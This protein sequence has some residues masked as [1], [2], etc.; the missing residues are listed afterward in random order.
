MTTTAVNRAIAAHEARHAAAA[1]LLGLD[2]LEARADDPNP[3]MGGYVQLAANTWLRPRESGIMTLAGRWGDLGWPPENP[4]KSGRTFDERNLADDVESL[5]RGQVGYRDMVADTERLVERP[6]FK[7]LTGVLESLL[8]AGCVLRE[9]HIRL[10]HESCGKPELAHKT[11]KAAA[12]VST[13]LGEFSALAAAWSHDRDGDQIVR[14]AF[15]GSIERWQ[16]SGKRVPLHYNHSANPKHIIGWVDP[17]SMREIREGLFVR[18]KLDLEN[19]EVARD[20]WQ[21]VKNNTISLSFGY[22]VNDASKRADGIQEL[23]EIDLFEVSLTPAPA[24]PDTRVLSFK[25]TDPDELEPEPGPALT[26]EQDRLREQ[27]SD[28]MYG[29]LSAPLASDPEVV[30]ER[31]EKRQNRELRR[32]CDRLQLEAAL[33]FDQDLIERFVA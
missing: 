10:V 12:R 32:R 8:A 9:D 15:A 13:D 31:E 1:L 18:G 20:V 29:L 27:F 23:R 25:S 30:L 26:A 16:A 6:E 19:S 7:L 14:G 17:A 11:I 3:E 33:G 2:V 4:S 24:N 5:G 21:L 28:E 22:L